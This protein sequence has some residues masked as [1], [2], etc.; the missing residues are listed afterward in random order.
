MTD[1]LDTTGATDDDIRA[2]VLTAGDGPAA[3]F[4][5]ELGTILANPRRHAPIRLTEDRPRD[6]RPREWLRP[7]LAAAAVLAIV[8]G[9]IVAITRRDNDASTSTSGP[10]TGGT[11]IQALVT[12]RWIA[13]DSPVPELPSMRFSPVPGRPDTLDVTGDDGCNDFGGPLTI[14]GN[15]VTESQISSTLVLCAGPTAGTVVGTTSMWPGSTL[16]LIN[17][18]LTVANESGSTR[19]VALDLLPT[20]V[21]ADLVGTWSFAGT[22]LMTL[23]ESTIE[24]GTCNVGWSVDT[25]LRLAPRPGDDTPCRSLSEGAPPALAVGLTAGPNTVHL[26]EGHVLVE[27]DGAIYRLDRPGVST[28]EAAP[29]SDQELLNGIVGHTWTGLEYVVPRLP[30]LTFVSLDS[31]PGVVAVQQNDGCWHGSGEISIDGHTVATSTIEDQ[32]GDC[33][34]PGVGVLLAGTELSIVDGSLVVSNGARS[35]EYAALDLLPAPVAADVVGTWLFDGTP[36]VTLTETTATIDGCAPTSWTLQAG[37]PQ[38]IFSDATQIASCEASVDAAIPRALASSFT[39]TASTVRRFEDHLLIEAEG[40]V[41]RLDRQTEALVTDQDLLDA[42]VGRTWVATEWSGSRLPTITFDTVDGAPD[43]YRIEGFDGCNDYGGTIVLDSD[44]VANAIHEQRAGVDCAGSYFELGTGARIALAADQVTFNDGGADKHFVPID[45]LPAIAPTVGAY[46]LDGAGLD[47]VGDR[48]TFGDCSVSWTFDGAMTTLGTPT[49]MPAAAE[50]APLIRIFPG[51]WRVSTD[52]ND[53]LVLLSSG[54]V[55]RIEQRA[56]DGSS[57]TARG[58]NPPGNQLVNELV[59]HVW[60]LVRSSEPDA[61]AVARRPFF[62]ILDVDGALVIGGA[63]CGGGQ[64]EVIGTWRAAANGAVIH[65]HDG[66]PTSWADCLNV[67]GTLPFRTV[68][69]FTRSADGTQ[70]VVDAD[71]MSSTYMALDTVPVPSLQELAG[72]WQRVVGAPGVRTDTIQLESTT[73]CVTGPVDNAD[74][75][76]S[77]LRCASVSSAGA[78]TSGEPEALAAAIDSQSADVHL[79]G[80]DLYVVHVIGDQPQSIFMLTRVEE[81]VRPALP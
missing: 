9:G 42:L 68:A 69:T 6:R 54:E 64:I 19:H 66:T 65:Q 26:F 63:A 67:S 71:G 50:F 2:A 34:P 24:I 10:L 31:R 52:G 44:V 70:V 14:S 13:V 38:A 76:D 49:C 28:P 41:Y 15:T 79:S 33:D 80:S 30:T 21:A 16:T 35:A 4:R 40:N 47:V 77:P 7:A 27:T 45:A 3:A 17:G 53:L 48:I 37:R 73:D 72:T 1:Q 12:H 8:V 59:N 46:G 22:Q 5:T 43:Q 57:V 78:T 20:P 39:S 55:L 23:T 51:P 62:Q 58:E 75:I 32:P 11:L 25:A 61:V 56:D 29:L 36:F 60:A 81:T 18:V 74:W